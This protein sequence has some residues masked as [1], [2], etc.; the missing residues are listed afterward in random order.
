[1]KG[2]SHHTETRAHAV[3]VA[4]HCG[5]G[6]DPLAEAVSLR[7]SSVK[8]LSSSFPPPLGGSHYLHAQG[9]EVLLPFLEGGA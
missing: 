7:W 1:M 3:N 6:L 4:L 8:L 2:S 9:W 5:V